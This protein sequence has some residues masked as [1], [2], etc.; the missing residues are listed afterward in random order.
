[1][2]QTQS[3]L[4][5]LCVA[6]NSLH[7]SHNELRRDV[8]ILMGNDDKSLKNVTTANTTSSNNNNNNNNNNVSQ[9]LDALTSDLAVVKRELQRLRDDA[10]ALPPP[11]SAAVGSNTTDASAAIE[12]A[13]RRECEAQSKKQRDLLEAL[14]TAKYDRLVSKTVQEACDGQRKEI[15]CRMESA[16]QESESRTQLSY[17]TLHRAFEALQQQM[18]LQAHQ[19][20][21]LTAAVSSASSASHAI[22]DSSPSLAPEDVQKQDVD[23]DETTSSTAAQL[24]T[25]M[26]IRDLVINEVT[27]ESGAPVVEISVKRGGGCGGRGKGKRK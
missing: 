16:C 1:M 21:Q 6:V 20:Q 2:Y 14:L 15:I 5:R 25:A 19:L 13:C 8:S 4:S 22:V 17:T 27:D 23:V 10:A 24:A 3:V 18:I 9:K 7:A 11:P 12:Q 26:S